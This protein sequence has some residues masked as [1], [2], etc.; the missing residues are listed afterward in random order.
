MEVGAWVYERF[1]ELTGVSF[2]PYTEHT[3]VQAPYQPI[4]E[5]EYIKHENAFPR[6]IDWK[7]LGTYETEDKTEGSK[8]LACTGDVC[9]FV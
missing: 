3:Y 5:E 8:T 9:E 6:A 2:L 7:D 4:T 1:D